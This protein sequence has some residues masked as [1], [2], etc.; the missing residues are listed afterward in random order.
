MAN[1]KT[2]EV[3]WMNFVPVRQLEI[4]DMLGG[5]F[6]EDRTTRCGAGVFKA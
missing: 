6:Y 2:Q 1:D 5:G 4:G 3:L